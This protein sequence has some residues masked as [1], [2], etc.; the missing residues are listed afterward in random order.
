MLPLTYSDAQ[1]TLPL[2]YSNAKAMPLLTYSNPKTILPLDLLISF[3]F[4][5][6]DQLLDAASIP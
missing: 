5:D 6:A 2:T 4:G 3:A 1:A